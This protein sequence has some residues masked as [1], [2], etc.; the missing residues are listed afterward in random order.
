MPA[1]QADQMHEQP[2]RVNPTARDERGVAVVSIEKQPVHGAVGAG[3]ARGGDQV[4]GAPESWLLSF[5]Q[6]GPNPK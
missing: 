3:D 1:P 6:A 2:K 5:R 4:S